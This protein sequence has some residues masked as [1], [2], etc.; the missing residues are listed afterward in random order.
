[1]A[2]VASNDYEFEAFISYPRSQEAEYF[3]NEYF[4]PKL[5]R[6]LADELGKLEDEVKIFIDKKHI[7]EGD[8]W[9]EGIREALLL[10]KC[11]VPVLTGSYF[12]RPWCHSEWTAFIKRERAVGLTS[13]KRLIV[14]VYFLDGQHYLHLP[15][16]NQYQAFDFRKYA[17][18]YRNFMQD[19]QYREFERD[20]RDMA[21]IIAEIGKRAPRF[22]PDWPIEQINL[23]KPLVPLMRI[24]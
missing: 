5:F 11:L 20:V 6:S 18:E 8:H 22:D 1:M 2:T 23:D 15:E 4:Y 24:E 19:P 3:V 21:E 13:V 14:P 10:S 9:P 7:T 17:T 12:S 16:V